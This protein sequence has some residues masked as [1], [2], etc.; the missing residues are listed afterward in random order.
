MITTEDKKKIQQVWRHDRE[1]RKDRKIPTDNHNV[2]GC[3]YM[4]KS[5]NA[6]VYVKTSVSVKTCHRC[7]S[8]GVTV[9]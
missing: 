6:Y 4:C 7:L 1:T 8:V 3:A 9:K 2:G 5:V